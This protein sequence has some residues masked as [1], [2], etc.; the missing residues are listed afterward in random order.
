MTKDQALD[1][2]PRTG[3]KRMRL[4]YGVNQAD[5]CW[6]FA[7]GPAR[8]IIQRRL[9]EID[10]RLI[11]LFLFDKQAPD[12]VE[13][14]PVFASYVQAVLDVG[15]VPMITFAKFRRPLDDPRAIR[16]F[17][18][19]CADVAWNCLERW[20]DI[21]RDWYWC[22]WNEPNSDWIGGGLTFDQYRRIY[23]EVAVAILRWLEP[24][25]D[26]RKP[27]IGG[28]A[29]EGF[30]P[31]WIDWAWRFV[32]E[33][34]NSLIGFV[35]WHYYGDWREHGEMGAPREAAVH[36]ALIMAQT[37]EYESRTRAI[38][39]H[40]AERD[41]R[42]ICGELN[43]HSHYWT[44]VR[45]RFNHSVFGATFYASALLYLMR[46]EADAEMFWTGNEDR[47]GYAMMDKH[48]RPRPA[49][50]AK[51]LITQ[52]VRYGDWI[53][54]PIQGRRNSEMDVVV[55]RGE[56]GRRSAVIVQLT[57]RSAVYDLHELVG[58]LEDCHT[59]HKLDRGTAGRNGYSRFDGTVGFDGYGIAVV[60]NVIPE[61]TEPGRP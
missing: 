10:T 57:D 17:A 22:V 45:E 49:F 27:L 59:L 50:H 14:W 11:R 15:A 36:H 37:P 34:D 38:G 43:A 29:I 42:N 48:G 51:K 6:D 46:G 4:H 60:T 19:Q 41:V 8:E 31:F 53:S 18:N 9:R 30:Q 12:P 58:G 5:E 20:G 56:D 3:E 16:W 35:D 47:G 61:Q 52:H 32:N 21:V 54:F 55:S 24:S 23:E 28:P 26:G 2:T 7:R 40:L 33:I 39:R 25:L 44:H 1:P 13:E